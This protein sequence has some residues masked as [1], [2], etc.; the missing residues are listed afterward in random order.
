MEKSEYDGTGLRRSP[1]ECQFGC[2]TVAQ[3]LYH[4]K[5]LL[6][7]V[8]RSAIN[9]ANERWRSNEEI[10]NEARR[11]IKQVTQDGASAR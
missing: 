8:L 5:A 1:T 11:K 2:I 4:L 6:F 7:E 3:T 10:T 9:E